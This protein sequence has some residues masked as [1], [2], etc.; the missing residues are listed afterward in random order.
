[1]YE[2]RPKCHR[3][4]LMLAKP[5]AEARL[6]AALTASIPLYLFAWVWISISLIVAALHTIIAPC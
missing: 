5:E 3:V 4:Y 2:S 1:M 6:Q